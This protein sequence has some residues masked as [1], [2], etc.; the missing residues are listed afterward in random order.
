MQAGDPAVG[1]DIRA[2]VGGGDRGVQDE[3][4]FTVGLERGPGQDLRPGLR[5]GAAG[6]AGQDGDPPGG[7][8]LEVGGVD[9]QGTHFGLGGQTEAH[10]VVVGVAASAVLPTVVHLVRAAGGDDVLR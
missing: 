4:V 8:A 10:P 1:E 7:V 6:V 3:A 2:H 9:L 5:V